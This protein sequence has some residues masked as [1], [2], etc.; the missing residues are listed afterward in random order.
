MRGGAKVGGWKQLGIALLAGIGL[1]GSTWLANWAATAADSPPPAAAPDDA[2]AK[3]AAEKEA[4]EKAAAEKAAK[5]AAAKAEREAA[6]RTAR[7]LLK[8]APRPAR[9]A[10]AASSLPL[11]LSKRRMP[12]VCASYPPAAARTRPLGE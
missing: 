11:R 5:E 10:L 12:S 2:A 4:A 8:P 1:T 6:F 7:E 3:A 9:A